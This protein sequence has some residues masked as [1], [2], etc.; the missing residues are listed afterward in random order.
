MRSLGCSYFTPGP[1]VSQAYLCGEPPKFHW[2]DSEKRAILTMD[3]LLN[4]VF[5]RR[6]TLKTV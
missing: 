2:T 3:I 1:D 4:M 5:L 6:R